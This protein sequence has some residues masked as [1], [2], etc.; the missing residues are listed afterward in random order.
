MTMGVIPYDGNCDLPEVPRAFRPTAVCARQE[1]AVAPTGTGRV[2]AAALIPG[3]E[4]IELSWPAIH[5]VLV[6]QS[7]WPGQSRGDNPAMTQ[8]RSPTEYQSFRSLV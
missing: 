2:Q 1:G 5:V 8:V 6:F 4:R 3:R 7:G